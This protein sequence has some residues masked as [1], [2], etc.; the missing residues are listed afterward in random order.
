MSMSIVGTL[1]KL[2]VPFVDADAAAASAAVAVER[3]EL[4]MDQQQ[5]L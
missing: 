5:P 4:K 2:V 3:K 1:Y